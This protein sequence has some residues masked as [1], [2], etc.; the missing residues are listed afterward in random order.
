[1]TWRAWGYLWAGPNTVF[2]LLCALLALHRGGLNVVDGVLEAHGPLLLWAL[3]HLTPVPGGA[4]AITFGHVVIGVSAE[5]LNG[6]RNH[7]R[8]H[9]RQYERWGPVFVPAY[10]AASAWML[11]SGR[12]PY[13]DNHFERAAY[14]E[15]AARLAT[16]AGCDPR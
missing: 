10:L 14:R 8:V 13:Y 3:R 5:A 2:G 15:D 16:V 11:V 1:M 12:D 6:V 9:V 4:A 7:E